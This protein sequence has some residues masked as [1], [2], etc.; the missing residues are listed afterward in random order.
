MSKKIH[1]PINNKTKKRQG[2]SPKKEKNVSLKRK[3]GITYYKY[4]AEQYSN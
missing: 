3:G 2:A 4:D 1:N